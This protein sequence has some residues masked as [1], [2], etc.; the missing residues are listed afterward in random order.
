MNNLTSLIIPPTAIY[1]YQSNVVETRTLPKGETNLSKDVIIED[2]S[3]STSNNTLQTKFSIRQKVTDFN[4]VII[5]D[6]ED[7]RESR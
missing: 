1:K 6:G 3:H 4:D 2:A 7:E 5:L